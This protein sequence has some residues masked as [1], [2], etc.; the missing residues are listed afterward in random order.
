MQNTIDS[1]TMRREKA[2]PEVEHKEFAASMSLHTT[3]L[4][5]ELFKK[6]RDPGYVYAKS[7]IR[8]MVGVYNGFT[9]CN[10]PNTA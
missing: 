9:F 2:L 4:T 3:M 8:F 10:L 7:W 6:Q 5:Q 1:V